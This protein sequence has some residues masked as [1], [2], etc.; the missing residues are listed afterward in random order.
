MAGVYCGYC[1][2][3]CFVY[4]EVFRDGV[5]F[6]AGHMATCSGGME[7]DRRGFGIDYTQAHN[8]ATAEVKPASGGAIRAQLVALASLL[9]SG[10]L[11][12][13]HLVS[14]SARSY[15]EASVLLMG[16]AQTG[17]RVAER[18]GLTPKESYRAD[19]TQRTHHRWLGEWNG[20]AV[21]LT[22]SVEDG[23]ST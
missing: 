5:R 2:L 14:A 19:G 22:V 13:E 15:A 21:E 17:L 12:G 23:E 11:D 1:G 16:D 8:P 6:W 3:R 18:V 10:H 7:H 20:V 9:E 4:R